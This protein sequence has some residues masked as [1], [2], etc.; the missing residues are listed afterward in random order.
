MKRLIIFCILCACTIELGSA[1]K[2]IPKIDKLS[3]N[4]ALQALALIDQIISAENLTHAE[5]L[6]IRF[7]EFTGSDYNYTLRTK[8]YDVVDQSLHN[9]SF[10]S[11]MLGLINFQNFLLVCMVVVGVVFVISLFFDIIVLLGQHVAVFVW[12]LISNGIFMYTF[13]FI[14][15]ITC[16][17]FKPDEISNSYIRLLFIFDWLTPLFGCIIFSI[18]YT[19]FHVTKIAPVE[20]GRSVDP[21][22]INPYTIIGLILSLV[23]GFVSIHH[24]NWMIGVGT[25]MMIFMTGGFML[26]SMTGGYYVGFGNTDTIGICF[27]LSLVL[28]GLMLFNRIGL[29]PETSISNCLVVFETGVF[30]WGTLVGSVAILIMSDKHYISYHA[31]KLRTNDY[32]ASNRE[33]SI[34]AQFIMMQMIMVI[35][36]FSLMFFGNMLYISSYTSIGGTFMVLWA[37]DMQRTIMKILGVNWTTVWLGM[38][39]ANLYALKQFI[40]FYPEYCLLGYVFG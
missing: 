10:F 13:G 20:N 9:R 26:G 25:I 37:L 38:C 16:M 22:T 6:V 19:H 32:N 7:K 18:T 4:E 24:N 30:F 8:L 23:W 27:S 15:S 5:S 2:T 29:F 35:Y 34:M 36:C 11:K 21:N 28:N 33:A 39:L 14:L 1:R 3:A 31:N 12:K 40:T 17:Y